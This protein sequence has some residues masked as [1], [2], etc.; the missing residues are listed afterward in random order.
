MTRAVGV[1]FNGGVSIAALRT[2]G[3]LAGLALLASLAGAVWM[4]V[5]ERGGPS[6]ADLVLPGGV[7]AT[8]TV[9]GG[10]GAL[11]DRALPG[12]GEGPPVMV[13]VHGYASDRAAMSVLARR[14]ARNGYAVLTLD[15]RGHGENRGAFAP[16]PEGWAHVEDLAAAVDWL[17][18]SREVD[19]TRVAVA[20]HSMGAGAA[21]RFAERDAGLDA[22]ILISGGGA[23]RG[24]HHPPNVLLLWASGDPERTRVRGHELASQLSGVGDV[25]LELGT[26]YGAPDER[27]AARADEIDGHDHSTILF[28]EAAAAEIV[29]WLDVTF[30]APRSGPPDLAAPRLRAALLLG[31]LLPFSMLGVGLLIGMLAPV[32]P[33]TPASPRGLLELAA[34]LLLALPFVAVAPL[35]AFLGLDVV[36]VLAPLLFGGGLALLLGRASGRGAPALPVLD[37]RPAGGV[38]RSLGA[39]AAGF[40]LV[41]ALLAPLGV[42]LHHATPT[43]A[44]ALLTVVLAGLLLPFFLGFENALRGGGGLRAL[45]QGAAGRAVALAAIVS[46]VALALVPRVVLLLLGPLVLVFLLAEIAGS[47]AWVRSHNRLAIAGF[48]SLFLAWLLALIM[49]LRL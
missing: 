42:V 44:R 43:P 14:V 29:A 33:P 35:G 17:R 15:L 41:Y 39:G 4:G 23:L 38:L 28:A 2:L 45:L 19:G 49:P 34:A 13:L 1:R 30:D 46:G 8:L 36:S 31:A 22:V 26:T 3:T 16:D 20:G 40:A 10:E 9:P 32:W 37:G 47:V 5:L 11:R 25:P 48:Q 6:H 21:L 18:V 12:L 24:P 27:H 7:P